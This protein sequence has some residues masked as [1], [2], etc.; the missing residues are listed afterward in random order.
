MRNVIYR[1]HKCHNIIIIAKEISIQIKNTY[2]LCMSKYIHSYS[3]DRS[4]WL[5]VC[6]VWEYAA[7]MLKKDYNC[8]GYR[9]HPDACVCT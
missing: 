2:R 1:A 6:C 8:C 3:A 7:K 5:Y 9:V 4:V